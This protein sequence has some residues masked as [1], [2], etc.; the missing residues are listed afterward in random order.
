MLHPRRG[1]TIV[2]L[3]TSVAVILLLLAVLLPIAWRERTASGLE[4]SI[5]NVSMLMAATHAY[6]A[7]HAGGAPMRA[8]GYSSGQLIGGWDGWNFGGKNCS[9]FW[10]GYF[11]EPAYARPLHAYVYPSRLRRPAGY[12]NSGSGATWR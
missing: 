7:D 8:C 11:D 6:T 4:D 9:T 2:E 3:L 10:S 1:F 12:H 5:R